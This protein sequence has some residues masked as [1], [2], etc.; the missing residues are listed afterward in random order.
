VL[1]RWK[2]EF[3]ERSPKLFEKGGGGQDERDRRIAELEGMVGRMALEL[4][5]KKKYCGTGTRA[6]A[7]TGAG[8]HVE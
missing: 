4:D 5:M 3:V 7:E 2:Q 1:S 6:G 8:S